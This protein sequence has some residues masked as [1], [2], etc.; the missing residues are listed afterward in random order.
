MG[1]ALIK[2]RSPVII[3]KPLRKDSRVTQLISQ[4][5]KFPYTPADMEDHLYTYSKY[6]WAYASVYVIANAAAGVELKLYDGFGKD[7]KELPDDDL[8]KVLKNPNPINDEYDIWEATYSFLELAGNCYWELVRENNKIK[9]IY[10]LRPD[11][12]KILGDPKKLV[13][14]YIYNIN[15]QEIEFDPSEILH[16][17]YFNPMSELYGF[18]PVTPAVQTMTID[19]YALT[20]NRNFFRMGARIGGVLETDRHLSK[21]AIDRLEESFSSDYGSYSNAWKTAVLQEG[22]KYKEIS[23]THK[24]MS[25]IELRKQAREEVFA[26]MGVFPILFGIME[27][28]NYATAHQQ[29]HLFYSGTIIP[30]LKKTQS[31][32][33]KLKQLEGKE[34]VYAK[35]DTE[36]IEALKEEKEVQS[37]IDAQYTDSGIKTINEIRSEHKLTPVSW[38][39]NWWPRKGTRTP[40]GVSSHVERTPSSDEQPIRIFNQAKITKDKRRKK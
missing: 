7:A 14:K 21:D 2:S 34:S 17:K 39:D 28:A 11:R 23:P 18:S 31:R 6:T 10:V 19:L 27:H 5:Y 4:E 13:G 32:I 3:Q 38:G 35:Y 20:Y 12:I 40:I 37:K 29:K 25:F 1:T 8:V 33:T 15:G 26:A 22:L 16:F 36:A 9:E 24:D 30:K